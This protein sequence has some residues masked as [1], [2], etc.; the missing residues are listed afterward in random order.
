MEIKL[1]HRL[2]LLKRKKPNQIQFE[3]NTQSCQFYGNF[4]LRTVNLSRKFLF[5]E[6]HLSVVPF[7]QKLFVESRSTDLKLSPEKENV[8]NE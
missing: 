3:K 4:D 6:S 7:M 8:Y 2:N 1:K 5:S